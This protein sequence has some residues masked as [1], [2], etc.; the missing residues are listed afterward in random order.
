MEPYAPRQIHSLEL[1]QAGSWDLK[2]YAVVYGAAVFD[3]ARFHGG[4]ALALQ[5]LPTPAQTDERP[6][7]GFVI[8][9]QGKVMDYVV[10]AWWDRENE[11]PLR[12]FVNERNAS[13]WRAAQGSESICVWDLEIIWAERNAYSETILRARPALPRQAYLQRQFLPQTAG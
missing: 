4:L 10:L 2:Q 13:A 9:H 7:V 5:S 3:L 11:L 12:V 8:Y 1:V 6:G